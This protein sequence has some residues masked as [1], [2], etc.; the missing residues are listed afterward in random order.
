MNLTKRSEELDAM[1]IDRD[2]VS[3][4]SQQFLKCFSDQVKI[5][6]GPEI[7]L[8]LNYIF[9][10]ETIFKNN[11]TPGNELQNLKYMFTE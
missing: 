11:Q 8:F 6:Y 4:L 7:S 9:W 1:N 5:K 3:L 10:R 2:C